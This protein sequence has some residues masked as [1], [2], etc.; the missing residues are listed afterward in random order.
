MIIFV[1]VPGNVLLVTVNKFREVYFLIGGVISCCWAQ[2]TAHETAI[3]HNALVYNLHTTEKKTGI[4]NKPV[5]KDIVFLPENKEKQFSCGYNILTGV[6]VT[7]L[8]SKAVNSV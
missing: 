6:F 7:R 8:S 3:C 2:H 1:T 4:L 5:F